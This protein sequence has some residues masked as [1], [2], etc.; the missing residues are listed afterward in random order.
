M[1]RIIFSVIAMA[2]VAGLIVVGQTEVEIGTLVSVA[3]GV[4][5]IVSGYLAV[6]GKKDV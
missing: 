4:G 5:T 2:G 1:W 6:K 3:I